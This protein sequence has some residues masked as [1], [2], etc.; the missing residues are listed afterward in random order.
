MPNQEIRRGRTPAGQRNAAI[1]HRDLVNIDLSGLFVVRVKREARSFLT[2][3]KTKCA[4]EAVG[5]ER[6]SEIFVFAVQRTAM[7]NASSPSPPNLTPSSQGRP[8]LER[9]WHEGRNGL[10]S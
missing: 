10:R 5:S 9:E 6:T 7:P 2:A 3:I 8:H 1:E 4:F